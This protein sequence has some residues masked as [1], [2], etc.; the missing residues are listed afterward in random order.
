ML[1]NY[2]NECMP[3][4]TD[5]ESRQKERKPHKAL[6]ALMSVL[7]KTVPIKKKKNKERDFKSIARRKINC[8]AEHKRKN[9]VSSLLSSAVNEALVSALNK[10]EIKHVNESLSEVLTGFVFSVI[11]DQA[12]VLYKFPLTPVVINMIFF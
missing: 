2:V 12:S 1:R 6:S 9:K 8:M 10:I 3:A 5:T 7:T 4:H 11:K